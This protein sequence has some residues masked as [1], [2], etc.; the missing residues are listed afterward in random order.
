LLKKIV[1]GVTTAHRL[2]ARVCHRWFAASGGI[3]RN[4]PMIAILWQFEIKPGKE[5]QF[6]AFHGAA[7]EW[8]VVNRHSRSYVGTSFLRDQAE[9]SRYVVIEYW[10]EMVVY[11]EHKAYRFDELD[12]LAARRKEL[13][14]S[15]EP[16]G[17]FTA[18]DVPDRTGAAWSRR[19]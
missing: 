1:T 10:S 12:R 19:R 15:F 18:L 17:V 5:E 7:G 2:V 6:E 11:E 3:E 4:R 16:L 9:P 14:V 13:V 8:S